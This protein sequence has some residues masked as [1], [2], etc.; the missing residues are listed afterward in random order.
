M[1]AQVEAQATQMHYSTYIE[2]KANLEYTYNNAIECIESWK[3]A[4]PEFPGRDG[5]IEYN[6]TRFAEAQ[7]A[8]NEL[9]QEYWGEWF[10]YSNTMRSVGKVY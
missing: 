3:A 4:E 2:R 5:M 7:A 8:L 1:S 6:E 9:E 10:G